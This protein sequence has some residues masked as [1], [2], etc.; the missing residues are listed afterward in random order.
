MVYGT[1]IHNYTDICKYSFLFFRGEV[2]DVV[3]VFKTLY[4]FA[5]E[6]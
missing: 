6:K 4:I 2:V 3:D 1:K 5:H